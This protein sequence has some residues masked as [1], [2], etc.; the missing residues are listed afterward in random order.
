MYDL[1]IV[2]GGPAGLSAAIKAG[3]LDLKTLIVESESHLGGI[4]KFA[5]FI[6]NYS[7][8]HISSKDY[9]EIA[10]E[11]IRELGVE[12][13]TSSTVLKIS[14][15]R[16]KYVEIVS[17]R[18]LI[19][20]RSGAV[21]YAA[22]AREKHRFELGILGDRVAGVY[23]GFEASRM[24]KLHGLSPGENVLLAYYEDAYTEILEELERSLSVAGL[25]TTSS[26]IHKDIPMYLNSRIL[27]IRGRGRVEYTI[28]ED[29][30]TG[31]R[32][33]VSCDSVVLI[34]GGVPRAKLLSEA[35]VVLDDKNTPMVNENFETSL[36][37]IFAA[38]RVLSPNISLK[39]II[40]QGE[41]AAISA[42]AYLE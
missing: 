8:N 32:R 1:I 6:I 20:E 11:R 40:S 12:I 29:L 10:I 30:I 41:R 34:T 28:L 17:P 14:S 25:V 42:Y 38:G 21:I 3:E 2:G 39:E 26:N 35:G 36:P 22:G 31:E 27:E 37:G 19:E 24:L 7:G 16:E 33:K 5:N 4:L 18:G 9:L 13:S 15:G 23:T